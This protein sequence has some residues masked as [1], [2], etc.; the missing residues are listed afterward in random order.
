VTTLAPSP[1]RAAADTTRRDLLVLVAVGLALRLPTFFAPAHLTF[2]DGV[3]GAS[4][5]AMRNGGVPFREVFSSQGPLF[6]PLVWL[7]DLLGLHTLNGPRLLGLASGVALVCVL[8]LA[9]REVGGVQGARL[10]GAMGALT[11]SA[12]AVTGPIAADGPAMALAATSVLIALRYRRDPTTA[13]AVAMGAVLGAAIMVKA[14]VLPAALPVGLILLWGRRVRDWVLAVG[15]SVLVGLVSSLVWGFS[16]VWDQSVAYHLEAPGGSEPGPNLVKVLNTFFTRDIL[17]LA[18]AVVTLVAVLLRRRSGQG[19]PEAPPGS[20]SIPLVL[21][22][23][24]AAMF[25]L[26]IMEH[27]L[28]RPHVSELV[29]P[30]S[31]LLAWYR[32]P[33]KAAVVAGA[34]AFP[35]TLAYAGPELLWAGDYEGDEAVVVETLRSLPDDALAISDEPGQVWRAG[36]RTPDDLVDTS[37]LRT[38]SG[39]ITA[40]SLAAEAARDEVCALVVWSD[41]FGE[42]EELPELLAGEGYEEA[43]R[44]DETRVVYVKRSPRCSPTAD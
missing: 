27:P 1:E 22:V 12:L 44:F 3:F 17:I 9:G 40:E 41:R 35:V 25:A 6:L 38:G 24:L 8:Y 14:L 33:W 37:V 34:L 29:P 26:L 20:P 4:A 10:A 15:A 13:K 7:A 30:A 19:S 32:P 11:G 31:L 43:E 21:W 2:D 28:W 39:R 23:W 42:F 36:R 5:V 16:D 18:L